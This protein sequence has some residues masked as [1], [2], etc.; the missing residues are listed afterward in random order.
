M[1]S[2]GKS[3]QLLCRTVSFFNDKENVEKMLVTAG[4]KQDLIPG[5]KEVE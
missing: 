4:S 3:N 2:T 5:N 1:K